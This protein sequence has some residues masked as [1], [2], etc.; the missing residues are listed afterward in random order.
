[1]QKPTPKNQK[2]PIRK[3]SLDW[4]K[5]AEGL[6]ELEAYL[7]I[8]ITNADII[9]IM[10]IS[11]ATFYNLIKNNKQFSNIFNRSRKENVDEVVNSLYKRALGY[12]VDEVTDEFRADPDG[13]KTFYRQKKNTKHIPADVTAAMFYLKNRDKD[14]WKDKQAEDEDNSNA[15]K[16]AAALVELVNSR[17][18]KK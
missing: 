16:L 18:V 3:Y 13:G 11:P 14:N 6:K 4:W 17:K 8:G 15:D 9:K 12:D 5:S 10:G 1:M 7:L 2:K